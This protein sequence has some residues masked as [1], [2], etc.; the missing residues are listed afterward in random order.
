[1]ADARYP[2]LVKPRIQLS[3]PVDQVSQG[4]SRCRGKAEVDHKSV[5]HRVHEPIDWSGL[6]S[7]PVQG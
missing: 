5:A 4:L 7:L 6:R 3:G 2:L 1:M